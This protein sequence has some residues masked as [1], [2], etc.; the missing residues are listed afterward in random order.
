MFLASTAREV[1]YGGAAAGG[2][3]DALI[4]LAL[5]HVD[6]PKHRAIILRRTR[7]QLQ[8]V[9]DRTKELYP[10]VVPGADWIERETRWRMPSGA[11]IQLGYAEHEDDMLAFKSFEYNDV[12]FDELTSFLQKMYLFMFSRNRT[13]SA[14]LP[15]RMRAASN[16]GDIGHQWVFDRFLRNHTPFAIY[17]TATKIGS[18]TVNTTRQFIPA[19]VYDNPKLANRDEYIAGLLEM[20]EEGLMY[21]NGVWQQSGGTMFKK[22]PPEVAHK[23]L[24][25]DYYIINALDYG[26]NDPNSAHWLAVYDD[27]T[28]D[29]VA[30]FY[31]NELS[32]DELAKGIKEIEVHLGLRAPLIRVADPKIFARES[33]KQT[34]ATLLADR[35]LVYE[36]ANNERVAGW[37]QL[38]RFMFRNQLRVWQGRAPEL[39][40]TL[41]NLI[42]NPLKPNDLKDRQEDHAADSLRYGVMA[43]FEKAAEQQTAAPKPRSDYQ[44]T[45][46]DRIV[47][48]AFDASQE[49][50]E[51]PDLGDW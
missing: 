51:I 46:F 29:V 20:G 30:E 14:D 12:F 36:K 28:I 15:P 22:Q 41:P 35:G 4:A 31:K 42:R 23:L 44:D 50:D 21:L 40:R 9:I 24:R 39:L 47:R 3:T 37:A 27:N 48:D 25:S 11:K 6:H 43:V 5:Q 8:E 45:D 38:Q 34:I 7:P 16:P 18:A 10:E 26:L 33:S 49:R 2:K 13:K 32:I 1:L 17:N 19:K